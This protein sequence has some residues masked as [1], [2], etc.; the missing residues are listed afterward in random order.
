L[1]DQTAKKRPLKRREKKNSKGKKGRTHLLEPFQKNSIFSCGRKATLK[2]RVNKKGMGHEPRKQLNSRTNPEKPYFSIFSGL[3][4]FSRK[5]G[6]MAKKRG[7]VFFAGVEWAAKAGAKAKLSL[8][9]Q[10]NDLEMEKEN[11]RTILKSTRE[12]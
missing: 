5:N 9:E 3:Q 7:E 8:W 4:L 11:R 6:M 1:T 12:Q 2:K 10:T